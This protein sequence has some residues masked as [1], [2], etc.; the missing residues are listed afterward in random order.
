MKT[1]NNSVMYYVYIIIN[2]LIKKL[3]QKLFIYIMSLVTLVT[4][5]LLKNIK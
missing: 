4:I 1:I 5:F 3:F 2:S